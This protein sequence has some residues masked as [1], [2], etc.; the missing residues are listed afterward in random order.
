E[1]EVVIRVGRGD[2]A[3][4]SLG[5]ARRAGD[6]VAA[7]VQPERGGRDGV[8]AFAVLEVPDLAGEGDVVGVRGPDDPGLLGRGGVHRVEVVGEVDAA[9]AGRVVLDLAEPVG[10]TRGHGSLLP[11]GLVV[12]DRLQ[13]VRRV[14]QG[15]LQTVAGVH[16]QVARAWRERGRARLHR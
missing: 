2:V 3:P 11:A 9:G 7:G 6:R 5:V 4:E 1:A 12:D 16:E 15:H 8:G 14:L 13:P 10:R